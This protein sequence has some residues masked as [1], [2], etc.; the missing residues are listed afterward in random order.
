MTADQAAT[1]GLPFK[2]HFSGVA[3]QYAQFRPRYPRSLFEYLAGQC[4]RTERAWDCACGSGQA[5]LA[6]AEHFSCVVATDASAAQVAAAATH[7]RV[8]YRVAPAEASGLE[9][10]SVDLVTVAQALHWLDLDAFYREVRRVLRPEGVLA[11]WCYGR[12]DVEGREIDALLQRFYDETI[13]PF[14]PPER[15]HVEAGYRHFPFPFAPLDP[16]P[17]QM[18]TSWSLSHLTGYLR[19]W[20]ATSRYLQIKGHDPVE[21]LE[22]LL[23]PLWGGEE[24][25]R[26]ITW[27]LSLRAGWCAPH[28]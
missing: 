22:Q 26:R 18:Q 5:S 10:A 17:L 25:T 12:F 7:P 21:P 9:P 24:R 11:V 15:A 1:S 13:G 16:P 3:G 6:L 20:S 8:L 27:P 2:D 4:A 14:W 23:R 28:A 19:S